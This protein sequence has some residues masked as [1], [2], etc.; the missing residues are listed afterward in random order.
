MKISVLIPSRGRPQ[1]LQECV[2][3]LHVRASG[4]HEITYAIGCD[5]DDHQTMAMS[6]VMRWAHG[7]PVAVH[8]AVRRP[9]LGQIANDLALAYPADIY[10]S[11]CD[12]IVAQTAGWDEAI[13]QTWRERPDGVW[14]WNNRTNATYA[15]VSEKWRAAAGRIFTDYFC[16][17]WDDLWLLQ[18]WKYASGEHILTANAWLDDRAPSTQRMR[19]LECW[20]KFYWSRGEERLAEARRIAAALGWPR[21]TAPSR[22][23]LRPDPAF[24]RRLTVIQDHQGEKAPPTPEYVRAL[25]RVQTIMRQAA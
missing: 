15:I 19:D 6:H 23:E 11:L 16:F 17:W 9:S 7:M 3:S 24:A 20:A 5:S 22:R 14:W 13:A 10:C 4:R 25:R 12:D 18:V 1:L 2:T 21:I 8:C